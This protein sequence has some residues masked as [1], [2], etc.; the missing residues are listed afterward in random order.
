MLT[1][2]EY[3]VLK[4]IAE[5]EDVSDAE[6]ISIVESLMHQGYV[7]MHYEA[8]EYGKDALNEAE[9]ERMRG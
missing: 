9:R 1:I 3:A 8:T 4:A 2:S 5:G 6:D 7:K